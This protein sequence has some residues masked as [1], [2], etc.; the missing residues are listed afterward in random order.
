MELNI[1]SWEIGEVE[2][3]LV[4]SFEK[5]EMLKIAESIKEKG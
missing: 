1:L 2:L 5:A 4:G 3:G